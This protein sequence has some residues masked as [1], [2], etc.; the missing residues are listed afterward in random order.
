M[1]STRQEL[2]VCRWWGGFFVRGP[3]ESCCLQQHGGSRALPHGSGSVRPA[4][5]PV[6]PL[7]LHPVMGTG[8]L[9]MQ[10]SLPTL[11]L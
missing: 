7:P 3:S 11:L 10:S 6:A 8:L 4:W 2:A 9:A 1:A 5:G